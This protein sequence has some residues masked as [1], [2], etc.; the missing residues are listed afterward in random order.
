MAA[1]ETKGAP[2]SCVQVAPELEEIKMLPDAPAPPAVTASR[3]PSDEEATDVVVW[4]ATDEFCATQVTP[5]SVETQIW[6]L[7][8]VAIS[9][10]PSADD[11]TA[12][13]FVVPLTRCVHKVPELEEV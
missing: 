2:A 4:P 10:F 1:H 5:E 3:E 7:L 9:L 13:Q 6:P 12:S 8:A 11:A